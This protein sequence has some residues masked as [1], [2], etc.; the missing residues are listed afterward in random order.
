M[1][2]RTATA[3]CAARAAA[4][5]SALR[6]M[7]CSMPSSR[8]LA[9]SV[10]ASLCGAAHAESGRLAAA[11][12]S[13]R[14]ADVGVASHARSAAAVRAAAAAT[15]RSAAGRRGRENVERCGVATGAS[16]AACRGGVRCERADLSGLQGG[17]ARGSGCGDS[18]TS[19]TG[20]L[21]RR[22]V[23]LS[24]V[25]AARRAGR[26]C[27]VQWE[28]LG[29]AVALQSRSGVRSAADAALGVAG[30][31]TYGS[32]LSKRLALAANFGGAS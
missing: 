8:M 15:E 23:S 2:W 9:A 1:A 10:C 21:S 22:R 16:R 13:T 32:V 11:T 20:K 29:V 4:L 30:R 27:G 3:S 7:S 19:G 25:A 12:E 5:S 26:W 28:P 14:T 18:G 31:C 6:C 17:V 24:G